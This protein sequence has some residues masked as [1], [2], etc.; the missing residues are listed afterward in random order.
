M[1][2]RPVIL[3]IDDWELS[4]HGGDDYH[5]AWGVK[6]L[7]RDVI[8]PNGG[9]RRPDHPLYL[10]WMEQLVQRAD[11]IT[12]HNSFLYQRFGGAFV[13]NGKDIS[14]FDP[15]QYD[16][17]ALKVR[18]GLS[19]YRTLMF[20]GA[21]RPY[22][23]LEDVLAALELLDEPDLRLVIVGGSPYDN[24]DQQLMQQWSSRIKRRMLL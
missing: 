5:Y 15:E 8:T 11:A 7:I 22:K 1:T 6:R 16:A 23:G 13:P 9:L 10:Q 4:W 14:L 24:Y 18:D 3:D 17:Q 21:P 19:E 12:V 20:P 2:H